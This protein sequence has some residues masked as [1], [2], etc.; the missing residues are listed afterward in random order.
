MS[1]NGRE[2][3]L[4]LKPNEY[5][6]LLDKTKGTVSLLTGSMKLSMSA[7]DALVEFSPEEK[8]FVEVKNQSDAIKKFVTVPENFYAILYNPTKNGDFPR[9]GTSNI[10]PELN[11]GKKIIIRGNKNFALFPGQMAK[12]IKGHTLRSNQYLL[13]RVYDNE[14][15]DK[16]KYSIGQLIVIKG[17]DVSFYIPT[18][19]FEVVP[20]R[21]NQ[22][23]R[24]A[25]TLERLEYCILKD[26]QGN[27]K[28]V[29][30]PAVVFP[31]PN[32]TFIINEEDNTPKF[33]AI[34]LSDISGIYLKV[35]A[36]YTEGEDKNKKTYRA[37]EELFITGKDQTIY[38]PRPEHAIISYDGKIIHHAIAI[39][40][41]EG[42]YV[43]N[44]KTGDVKMVKGPA[45]YL[46]DP[47][48]EV[49]VRRKLT[50]KQCELWYPGNNDVLNY[51]VPDAM[52]TNTISGNV[53]NIDNNTYA[54]F[55]P[56]ITTTTALGCSTG[57]ILSNGFVGQDNATVENSGFKRGNTYTKPRTIT[58][59]N[60]FDG[61]VTIDIWTGYAIN[62]V[63]KNGNRKVVV[64]PQTYLL[65]YDETLEVVDTN[66]GQT[67][68]LKVNNNKIDDLVTVQTKD[69]VNINVC[70]SYCVSFDQTK[71]DDWFSIENY[72]SFLKDYER[73]NIKRKVKEFTL[74]EFYNNAADIIRGC[75]L[76]AKTDKNAKLATF[77]NGMY[78]SDVEIGD[79]VIKNQAV[80][81]LLDKHQKQ[82]VEK[83]LAISTANKEIAVSKELSK[84]R[85]EKIDLDY[86]NA[87]HEIEIKN[88][89]EAERI[90]SE[91]EIAR[92][93]EAS[94]K[95]TK[96]A[97]KNLQAIIDDIKKSE[98]NRLKM[99]NDLS[100]ATQKELDKLEADRQK[101]YTDSVKKVI[102]SISP[103]LIAAVT[104]SSHE[105]ML[106]EVAQ[107]LS[108]YALASGEES[109]ADVVDK[110]LRGTS[111][112]GLLKV[113]IPE[114]T[115]KK[116]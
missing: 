92:M 66:E 112:E 89:T 64:G 30:G 100:V 1:D 47:R 102:D 25:V 68:Y 6:D 46:P 35:V 93:K 15:L 28:Y 98:L 108:P 65:A 91:E 113:S 19:G 73:S 18:T 9:I 32:E 71:K 8:R 14:Q 111:M 70:I 87:M 101:S 33:K 53:I 38:Y 54:T 61:V 2:N 56:S 82:I 84:I 39:P 114:K 41:G 22:Y 34:E 36:D 40:N 43:L 106:K 94:E 31:E 115:D 55:S 109:V 85:Q 90:R 17:T 67:V 104:T 3:D 99:E 27:K 69:F 58:I 11:I 72:V 45:M 60:K 95:A 5:C 52:F 116:A 23:V 81:E 13:V 37:G 96:E 88:K 79:V 83:S 48:Y 24:D 21:D 105:K 26:E 4:I 20:I 78:V 12:V 16:E 62:V 59:D 76:P 97:E 10:T 50:K 110:L 7:S 51:N 74:E 107:S 103:D 77:S 49:I 57:D 75:V 42:R 80:G 29:H 63:S 86:K 44:R